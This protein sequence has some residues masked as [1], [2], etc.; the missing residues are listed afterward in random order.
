MAK[1]QRVS[2]VAIDLFCGAGGLT[3][4]LLDA[5]VEVVA[6]YDI[7]EEC[8]FP[9]ESN[10]PGA[11]FYPKSV[12]QL[13]GRALARKYPKGRARILVGCTP[14][15]TFSKYTQGLKKANDPKWTLLNDFGRLV[16]ELRPDIVSIENVPELAQYRIFYKFLSVLS[17]EGFYF[18][19][20]PG[21][22]EVHCPDYGVPQN[23]RRL[24]IL[25]S[26]IGPIELIS[27]THE[28]SRYLRVA[29]M[30]QNLPE[31]CAGDVCKS[32]PLHRASRLSERNLERIRASRPG[33][34]WRDWP[35]RLRSE[36]H[37]AK[38]GEGYLS[39]YGRMEWD[40]PAPTITTQFYGYGS[41]RFGHPEQ[42]RAL[43]LREG[44]LLQSFPRSYKFAKPD[45]EHRMK[46]IG[47]M[48]GNAVPVRLGTAIGRSIM[49][50]LDEHE[51]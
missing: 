46:C 10:N 49:R 34:T 2:P 48:I 35:P 44:A 47:R 33:G 19:Q 27:P 23:R 20:D 4:G 5:G 31:L 26:R 42:D 28:P 1:R 21:K 17:S 9:Y 15:Q 22:W 11:C 6:G 12:T 18:E 29:D 30:I 41:G 13:S 50:H 32:D 3:R 25:A 14:C 8:R 43:S 45:S 40:R 24:V 39:V 16:R 7:D 36:C 38:S 51:T 37:K